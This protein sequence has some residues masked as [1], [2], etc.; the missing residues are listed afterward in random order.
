MLVTCVAGFLK[1]TASSVCHPLQSH[2][3]I[4]NKVTDQIRSTV[5]DGIAIGHPCCAVQDCPEAL[6]HVKKRFCRPHTHLDS[7]CVVTTCTAIA[8]TDFRTCADPEHRKL[9]TYYRQQGKAMFQLK[10]RLERAKVSQTHDSLAAGDDDLPSPIRA[11][12]DDE[13][14]DL[15]DVEDDDD[16]EDHIG[17]GSGVQG[18]D[19]DALVDEDGV[20]DGKPDTG[21]KSVRARFGRRRTH[22]EEFCVGS[23][24]VILGRATFYGSEAP[25]GVR[26]RFDLLPELRNTHIRLFVRHFGCVFS[27]P[28]PPFPLSSGMTI[29]AES[30]PC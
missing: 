1:R 3:L 16:N 29:T 14:P 21:N 24:G 18:D 2:L 7:L 4:L 30:E 22:N 6:P 11:L 28:N 27:L 13:I 25:N 20:C 17:E 12:G 19:D 15:V 8:S 9:E 23:C 26:V 5:T 10:H